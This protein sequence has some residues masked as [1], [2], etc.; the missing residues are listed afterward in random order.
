[1][2]DPITHR[3]TAAPPPPHCTKHILKAIKDSF[4]PSSLSRVSNHRRASI[5]LHNKPPWPPEPSGTSCEKNTVKGF[6]FVKD[7]SRDRFLADKF[8]TDQRPASLISTR[9][10]GSESFNKE[11]DPANRIQS[12]I[13]IQS[14]RWRINGLCRQ[15]NPIGA[16]GTGRG[17]ER[18]SLL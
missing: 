1:M 8:A 12:A 4:F 15:G 16:R 5:Y 17:G 14:A 11:P 10:S 13:A 6:A 9:H 2:P 18:W 3:S 7:H